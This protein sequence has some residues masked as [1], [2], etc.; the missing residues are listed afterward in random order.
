MLPNFEPDRDSE[1][2]PLWFSDV[3]D[4]QTWHAATG[5]GGFSGLRTAICGPSVR[6]WEPGMAELSHL[7]KCEK[8]VY[9]L[10]STFKS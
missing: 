2:N 7:L 6:V 1:G 9:L 5:R 3:D 8:C 10:A 4:W